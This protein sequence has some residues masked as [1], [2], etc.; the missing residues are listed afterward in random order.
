MK[1]NIN[2]S[3]SVSE[4]FNTIDCFI[5]ENKKYLLTEK[6]L[7][8]SEMKEKGVFP[9]LSNEQISKMSN[10]KTHLGKTL[11]ESDKMFFALLTDR[12][13]LD[14]DYKVEMGRAQE[15]TLKVIILTED[16]FDEYEILGHT[17]DFNQPPSLILKN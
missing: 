6:S 4:Y 13:D 14:N 5:K 2:I 7:T 10:K 17:A 1:T 8:H 16:E 3:L 12:T 11:K 9:R 15:I